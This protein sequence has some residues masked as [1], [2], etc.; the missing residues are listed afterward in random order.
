MMVFQ[1]VTQTA[2]AFTGITATVKTIIVLENTF[3]ECAKVTIRRWG[4]PERKND[5][6]KSDSKMILVI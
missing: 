6:L 4:V 3:A 2:I 5:R 1:K